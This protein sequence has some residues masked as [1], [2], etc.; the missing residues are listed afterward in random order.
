VVRRAQWKARTF[1]LPYVTQ[2]GSYAPE[3]PV[4]VRFW[5]HEYDLDPGTL[6]AVLFRTW[7]DIGKPVRLAPGM[8][9]VLGRC[10]GDGESSRS[11]RVQPRRKLYRVFRRLIP[12]RYL[13]V[14][15]FHDQR[16]WLLQLTLVAPPEQRHEVNSRKIYIRPVG[17]YQEKTRQL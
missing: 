13:P 2:Y 17:S 12:A 8:V 9:G 14:R 4:Q 15:G 3:V 16:R 5:G 1:H 11:S 7:S 10:L 6:G